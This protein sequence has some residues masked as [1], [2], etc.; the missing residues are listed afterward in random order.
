MFCFFNIME[1][2]FTCSIFPAVALFYFVDCSELVLRQQLVLY[3]VAVCTE[4]DAGFV[5]CVAH[6]SIFM[7]FL[8]SDEIAF[9]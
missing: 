9:A 7:C 5:H 6:L 4:C 1:I 8:D 2:L 3:S